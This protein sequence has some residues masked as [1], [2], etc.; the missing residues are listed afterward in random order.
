MKVSDPTDRKRWYKPIVGN[1]SNKFSFVAQ[2]SVTGL[3]I[4][5]Q[6]APQTADHHS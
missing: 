2:W 4:R 1:L 3:W 6:T 5:Q